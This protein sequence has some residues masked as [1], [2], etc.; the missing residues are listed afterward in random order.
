M[1]EPILG[2]TTIT[3]CEQGIVARLQTKV[4]GVAIEPF[5]DQP[6]HYRLVHQRGALLVCYRGAEYGELKDVGDVVQE[7]R[8]LFDVHVLTRQL[9][10]HQGSYIYL[11]AA[12]QTLTGTRLPGFKKIVPRRE[13]FI[14]H[15]DG[16]WTFALTVSA[17]TIATELD[18]ETVDAML[19]RLTVAGE[20]TT[21]EVTSG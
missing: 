16:V 5:P 8:L 4:Q 6:E 18:E 7:R 19:K 11:E 1:S 15:K 2:E 3:A 17:A 10:G 9:S 12:R 13:T 20:Y 14:G 21:S